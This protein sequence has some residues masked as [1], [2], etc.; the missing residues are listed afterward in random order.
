MSAPRRTAPDGQCYE[1]ATPAELLD[2]VFDAHIEGIGVKTLE[3]ERRFERDMNECARQLA[4]C[5]GDGDFGT[6]LQRLRDYIDDTDGDG[7]PDGFIAWLNNF[8][9]EEGGLSVDV[10]EAIQEALDEAPVAAPPPANTN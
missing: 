5:F 4:G 7:H 6:C 2:A 3:I 9:R 8:H 1:G 10:R